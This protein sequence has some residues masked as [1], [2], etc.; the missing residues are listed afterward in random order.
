MTRERAEALAESILAEFA[1]EFEIDDTTNL[2]EK[3]LA[4]AAEAVAAER[5]RCKNIRIALKEH[6]ELC[7]DGQEHGQA[8]V[9]LICRTRQAIEA[10]HD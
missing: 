4:Y 7:D 1:G 5:A 10:S 2:T 6:L 9:C 8:C 3:L